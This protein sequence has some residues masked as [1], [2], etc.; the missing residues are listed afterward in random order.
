MDFGEHNLEVARAQAKSLSQGA[1]EIEHLRAYVQALEGT[2]RVVC[3]EN[4]E[5]C[6]ALNEVQTLDCG[7]F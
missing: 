7:T 4:G 2:I 1:G 5:Y 6:E 3:A